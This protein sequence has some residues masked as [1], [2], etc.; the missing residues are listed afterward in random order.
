MAQAFL[1]HTGDNILLPINKDANKFLQ[2]LHRI[3]FLQPRKKNEEKIPYTWDNHTAEANTLIML[4][5]TQ[6]VK[7]F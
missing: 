5:A 4:W 1:S 2:A 6:Q 7:V 3:A